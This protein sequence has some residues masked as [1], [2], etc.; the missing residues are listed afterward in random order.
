MQ[1]VQSLSMYYIETGDMPCG[2]T[3]RKQKK[4]TKVSAMQENNPFRLYCGDLQNLRHSPKNL[5]LRGTAF[6]KMGGDGIQSPRTQRNTMRNPCIALCLSAVL[7]F[8][9]TVVSANVPVGGFV[10]TNHMETVENVAGISAPEWSQ[11][12]GTYVEIMGS[13]VQ[14]ETAEASVYIRLLDEALPLTLSWHGA[15][16]FQLAAPGSLPHNMPA[17]PASS[18]PQTITFRLRIRS[19]QHP[20]QRLVLE[21]RQPGG[22]WLKVLEKNM[23]L[24]LNG[25]REW[26]EEGGLLR[27]GIAGPVEWTGDST[28]VR[29][30]REGTLLLIK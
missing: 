12:A 1:A 16:G 4:H 14:T 17:A 24:D 28:R 21:T 9:G 18:G 20:G 25:A 8:T 27:V 19:L 11:G 7:A 26:V 5:L 15:E 23:A 13:F 29:V 2:K 10:G 3:P 22:G 30:L 6:D